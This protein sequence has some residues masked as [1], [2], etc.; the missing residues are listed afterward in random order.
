MSA[1]REFTRRMTPEQA[2]PNSYANLNPALLDVYPC[3]VKAVRGL[4]RFLQSMTPNELQLQN[5]TKPDDGLDTG[6]AP[7]EYG[8]SA[9]ITHGGVRHAE[10]VM[11]HALLV[12][13]KSTILGF[14]H[15]QARPRRR[16]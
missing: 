6:Q 11:A 1:A 2:F 10:S 16:V 5:V 13:R 15:G 9:A 12:S 4:G 8:R 3:V 7:A 14:P